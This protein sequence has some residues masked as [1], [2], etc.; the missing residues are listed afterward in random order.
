M[1]RTAAAA[2]GCDDSAPR[3]AA[4]T[5]G[6]RS[7]EGAGES[8]GVVGALSAPPSVRGL[9][10][11]VPVAGREVELGSGT[12]LVGV[13]GTSG[14]VNKGVVGR[15]GRRCGEPGG[16]KGGGAAAAE[17]GR[18]CLRDCSSESGPQRTV[19]DGAPQMPCR[20]RPSSAR[21]APW[22]ELRTGSSTTCSRSGLFDR[23]DLPGRPRTS[24][25]CEPEWPS[26]PWLASRELVKMGNLGEVGEGEPPSRDVGD[27]G[28][29]GPDMLRR[30]TGRISPGP[31]E[32]VPRFAGLPRWVV[33]GE[34]RSGGIASMRRSR[35]ARE[36]STGAPNST[37]A[38]A[39][40]PNNE[41]SEPTVRTCDAGYEVK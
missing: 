20:Y 33:A 8:E 28:E 11:G 31:G 16:E 35:R 15:S 40:Q 23:R 36:G 7:W 30:A 24:E 1:A 34:A 25:P 29:D 22:S 14:S 12:R 27:E 10:P 9:L 21:F 37:A 41:L 26:G 4:L 39:L 13:G 6:S 2:A 19:R 5:V 38:S 17:P 3:G 18:I 32:G